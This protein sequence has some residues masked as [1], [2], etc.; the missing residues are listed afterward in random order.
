MRSVLEVCVDSTASALAAKRGG[1]S[2][3]ELCAD[4]IVGGTTPSLAL[5][6]QVKAETGLPV[7]ALLRPRFGDFCYDSY[8]LAQ[9]E[10]LAAELQARSEEMQ[11]QLLRTPRIVG[12]RRMLRAYP[13]LRHGS[14]LRSLPTLREMLHRAE[15]EN[16]DDN[17]NTK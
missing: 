5:V 15:Q 6:R 13:K 14:K 10:Q 12:P 7:R 8:E 16:K 1:A 4:L 11:A 9:M 3:L 17:K 2:R